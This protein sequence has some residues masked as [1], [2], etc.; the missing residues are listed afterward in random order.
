MSHANECDGDCPSCQ[1][2]SS[3]YYADP[4][5][6]IQAD[7]YDYYYL[8]H[9]LFDGDKEMTVRFSSDFRVE[10][11]RAVI[12]VGEFDF[13]PEWPKEVMQRLRRE[14]CDCWESGGINACSCPNPPLRIYEEE[15]TKLNKKL[16]Y[17][18]TLRLHLTI[19]HSFL[20]AGGRPQNEQVWSKDYLLRADSREEKDY[21]DDDEPTTKFG[22]WFPGVTVDL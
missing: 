21:D 11:G 7:P 15:A 19:T 12:P 10:A 1:A 9:E 22:V 3:R 8:T 17:G 2:L 14:G 5:P 18:K 4:R 16:W 13:H 6:P 20:V